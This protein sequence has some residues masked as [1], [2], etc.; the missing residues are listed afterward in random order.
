[1]L[2]NAKEGAMRNALLGWHQKIAD[3]VKERRNQ[4]K[5]VTMLFGNIHTVVL[6]N[7]FS[8]W[9]QLVNEMNLKW[10]HAC[11]TMNVL[12]QGQDGLSLASSF[13][14]WKQVCAIHARD[15]EH[16]NAGPGWTFIG[17]FFF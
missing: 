4:Q 16:I 8:G 15:N 17:K 5:M 13:F 1:M 3:F 14:E 9:T 2:G 12:I 11:K 10:Q 7:A 6:R